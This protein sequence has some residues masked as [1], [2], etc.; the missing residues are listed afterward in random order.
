VETTSLLKQNA[1]EFTEIGKH[2]GKS[3]VGKLLAFADREVKLLLKIPCFDISISSNYEAPQISWLRQK[4]SIVFEDNDISPNWLYS[5]F[6]SFI[7]CPEAINK[8]KMLSMG[9]DPKKLITYPGYKEDIYIAG[10]K[11]NPDF[12][13]K[14]PFTDFVTVR[15]ENLYATY[16]TKKAVSIVPELI[17][18]LSDKN[19]NIL[20]LPRYQQDL[21][22]ITK[23]KNIFIPDSP[24]NGLD[25][26]FYSKAVLTGAGT[27]SREAS[28]MGKPAVSF[29]AGT[30]LLSVDKQLIKEGKVFFSRN[31]D[32]I[33]EF[34][35]SVESV[36]SNLNRSVEVQKEVFNKI[37][38]L[39]S[40]K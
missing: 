6:A 31:A 21:A 9:V 5:K 30:T 19:F 33:V 34:I 20:Y 18:K 36:P 15:P 28:L 24:L 32:E 39:I 11:F 3:K 23:Q 2:G 10:Y 8:Q 4:T 35:S 25:V 13:R 40:D 38:Q 29:F 37:D 1:I 7:L 14:I 26:C 16:V 12:L 17:N 22:Y 27:F